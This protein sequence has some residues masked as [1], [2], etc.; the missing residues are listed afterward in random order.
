M[1]HL[2]LQCGLYWS[3]ACFSYDTLNKDPASYVANL[4]KFPDTPL[5][6]RANILVL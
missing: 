5:P 3:I 4:A 1:S 2:K 6:N